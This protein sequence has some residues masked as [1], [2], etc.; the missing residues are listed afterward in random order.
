MPDNAA[1]FASAKVS[2]LTSSP[3]PALIRAMANT[4]LDHDADLLNDTAIVVTLL[5]A[6]FDS[7]QIDACFNAA[8]GMALIRQS[9]ADRKD[10]P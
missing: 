9:N 5:R 1:G 4:L 8:V 3:P 2:S 6:G 7:K 10:K